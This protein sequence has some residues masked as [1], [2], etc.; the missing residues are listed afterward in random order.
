MKALERVDGICM[1]C[2]VNRFIVRMT[3]GILELQYLFFSRMCI[4]CPVLVV[5]QLW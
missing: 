4:V 1:H 5:D 3:K 2:T